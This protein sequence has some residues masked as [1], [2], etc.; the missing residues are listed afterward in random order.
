MYI[1]KFT[2]FR[3]YSPS[4]QIITD[5]TDSETVSKGPGEVCGK[6]AEQ[7]KRFKGLVSGTTRTLRKQVCC[8]ADSYHIIFTRHVEKSS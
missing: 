2:H 3:N 4:T 6:R 8:D 1:A 5:L 7:T